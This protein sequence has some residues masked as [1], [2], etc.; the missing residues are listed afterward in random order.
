MELVSGTSFIQIL[1]NLFS[2]IFSEV[3]AP[4]LLELLQIY[5][6]Y[7]LTIFWSIYSEWLLGIFVALCSLV[8]KIGR[9][10]CRERVCQY[11]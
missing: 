10:S 4:I 5:A 7:I 2:K 9:A 8:D 1:S 11:V 3:F 6:K